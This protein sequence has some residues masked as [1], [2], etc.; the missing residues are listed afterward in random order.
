M[1]KEDLQPNWENLSHA[2]F[3]SRGQHFWGPSGGRPSTGRANSRKN[4]NWRAPCSVFLEK[5][6]H[7]FVLKFESELEIFGGVRPRKA[8]VG[9]WGSFLHRRKRLGRMENGT[10]RRSKRAK[11]GKR[12]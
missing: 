9:P 11:K 4:K 7:S 10:S 5:P 2:K 1:E 8:H 3:L 6:N 12:M